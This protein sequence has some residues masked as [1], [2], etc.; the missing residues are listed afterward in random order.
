M[1][2]GEAQP[3]RR[4]ALVVINRRAARG[5]QRLAPAL[6]LLSDAGIEIDLRLIR[7]AG[8]VGPIIRDAAGG[9]DLVIVGGGDGTLSAAADAQRASGLPLGIL[10]MG[11]ANDLARTLG[12]PTSLADACRVI[13]GGARRPIDLGHVNGRHFFNVASIGLSVAIA[14]RLTGAIKQRWGVLGYLGCAWEAMHAPTRFH[15]RITGDGGTI[16]VEAIQ[17]AIG[18]GRHYGGGMTIIDDAA[19]DDGRLDFYA[20]PP[21]SRWRLVGLVAVLRW[22][23]HRQVA[24]IHVLH[25]T[26]FDIETWPPM[27]V[28]IDG[29]IAERT[30]ATFGIVPEAL[31][32]F[33][34]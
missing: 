23:K 21:Q 30:P 15:A 17:L 2:A 9:A 7:R 27:K 10:P 14:D 29:E 22:G 26:R 6:A 5:R 4:R 19:I 13:A 18:N 31:E 3:G 8:K 12:I 25:G 33:V 20:L 1:T 24:G 32:V 28:N 11:N 16:E 34:P